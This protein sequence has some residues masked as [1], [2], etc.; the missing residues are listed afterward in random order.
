MLLWSFLYL[1]LGSTAICASFELAEEIESLSAAIFAVICLF[2]SLFFA[3]LPVQ[4]L[5]A[6]VLLVRTQSSASTSID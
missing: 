5:V 2:L 1:V 4:L 3:P 6:M